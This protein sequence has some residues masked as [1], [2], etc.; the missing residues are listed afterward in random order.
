MNKLQLER[1]IAKLEFLQDQMRAEWDHLDFLLKQVGFPRGI[2]SA[3]E[4]AL[5]ILEETKVERE[6]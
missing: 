3:K 2:Q 6:G 5:Q 4:V 1:K